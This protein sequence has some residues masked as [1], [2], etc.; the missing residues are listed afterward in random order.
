MQISVCPKVDQTQ[1]QA[2]LPLSSWGK[3][4]L[5]VNSSIWSPRAV[6]WFLRSCQPVESDLFATPF[7]CRK[8]GR[9]EGFESGSPVTLCVLEWSTVLL[10]GKGLWK[11]MLISA[12][13]KE[14]D[15]LEVFYV[16]SH[17]AATVEIL[18]YR[19]LLM[20][21]EIVCFLNTFKG[22]WIDFVINVEKS[23]K[24]Y[25]T[26]E[27]LYMQLALNHVNLTLCLHFI[28]LMYSKTLIQSVLVCNIFHLILFIYF[29]FQLKSFLSNQLFKVAVGL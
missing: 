9:K 21:V 2:H 28:Y 3:W 7:R 25:V 16:F 19:W 5:P 6:A 22:P 12:H 20:S 10:S 11:Q 8:T 23:G 1:T 14:K 24:K 13:K 4:N 27:R 29:S 18:Y 26:K 15:F 17:L